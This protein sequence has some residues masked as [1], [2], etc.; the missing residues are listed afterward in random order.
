[1]PVAE[2]NNKG[3]NLGNAVSEKSGKKI[4]CPVTWTY[5]TLPRQM[6][7]LVVFTPIRYLSSSLAES[8]RTRCNKSGAMSCESERGIPAT[9]GRECHLRTKATKMDAPAA[10]RTA[11]V[12]T[13]RRVGMSLILGTTRTT[14]SYFC[15]KEF[16]TASSV[17]AVWSA[18]LNSS[19][20]RFEVS[21]LW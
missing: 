11:K 14:V 6:E 8:S 21:Q 18:A 3:Q 7:L 4:A 15:T 2:R 13:Q 19:R 17:S 10:S 1:M 5:Q 12:M 16:R 9:V 20:I